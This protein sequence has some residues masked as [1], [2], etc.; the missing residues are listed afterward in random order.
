M[1]GILGIV[2]NQNVAG[3]LYD[4]L[5]VLQHRGQ[6]AAGIATASGTRLRVQR[7]MVWYET[8]STSSVWRSLMGVLGLLI[9]VI[10]LRVLRGWMRHNLLRQ[11]TVRHCF[12]T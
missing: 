5:T 6:D 2:G 10:Q 9:A 1:C 4:G 3:Q 12:S 11:L 8:Y 7:P